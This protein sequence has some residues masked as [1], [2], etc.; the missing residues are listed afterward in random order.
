MILNFVITYCHDFNPRA[1]V[2]RDWININF[3]SFALVDFNPRAPV[4]RDQKMKWKLKRLLLIY[5]NPRAPVGRDEMKLEDLDSPYFISIHAPLWDATIFV[6]FGIVVIVISIHAPLWDATK[7]FLFFKYSFN[8][9]QST[10]PCGTRPQYIV[11]FIT[12]IYF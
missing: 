11:S 2:G 12:A 6:P 9:F 10:R 4:G 3:F 7:K 5:F 1:P 8:L